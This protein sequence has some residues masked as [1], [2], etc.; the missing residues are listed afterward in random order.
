[1]TRIDLCENSFR[2]FVIPL[3]GPV[4]LLGKF[5]ELGYPWLHQFCAAARIL[6]GGLV[7][8]V[9]FAVLLLGF[10]TE[11]PLFS[12]FSYYINIM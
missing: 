8:E 10:A 6:G 5:G 2:S 4:L 11:V 1:M 9:K 7:G 12:L 3:T